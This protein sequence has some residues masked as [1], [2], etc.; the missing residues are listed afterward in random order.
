MTANIH[1]VTQTLIENGKNVDALTEASEYGRTALQTVAQ[2][3]QEIAKDSWK[4]T[5]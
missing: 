1:S 5:L 2:E 3:I 4:S